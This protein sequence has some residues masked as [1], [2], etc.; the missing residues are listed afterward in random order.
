[1]EY[2]GK[3]KAFHKDGP[4]SLL[5]DGGKKILHPHKCYVGELI[6]DRHYH[7]YVKYAYARAVLNN[8]DDLGYWKNLYRIMQRDKGR[9]A[10]FK[11][12]DSLIESIKNFGFD[13]NFPIPVDINYDILD[14]S[15]RLAVLLAL[16]Q[17][18]VVQIYSKM[19]KRYEKNRFANF[20]EDYLKNIDLVR[21]E[22]FEKYKPSISNEVF[23]T[24][25]GMGLPVWDD[26]IDF[27]GKDSIKRA[28]LRKFSDEEYAAF[29]KVMYSTDSIRFQ[30]LLRK[31]WGIT[32]FESAAGIIIV[33]KPY[34]EMRSIKDSIRDKF[35]SKVNE[36]H[37][38]SILHTLDDP[39]DVKFFMDKLDLYKP[40][41]KMTS[42]FNIKDNL[43]YMILNGKKS[44]E[45]YKSV[46]KGSEKTLL[47]LI[48]ERFDLVI[49]DLD[50]TIVNSE[51][52][53]VSGYVRTLSEYG[54]NISL[55]NALKLFAGRSKNDNEKFIK[56]KWG[57]EFSEK[58]KLNK[59]L[60]IH[61]QKKYMSEVDGIKELVSK[62]KCA[63]AVASGSS[64]ETI[65]GSLKKIGLELEFPVKN[66]FSTSQV[67]KGKPSPDVFIL[68]SKTLGVDPD[69]CIVIEDSPDGI[70]AAVDA[71]M[72]FI[73]FGH[74][75]HVR[76]AYGN[77]DLKFMTRSCSKRRQIGSVKSALRNDIFI[78]SK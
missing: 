55:K 59:K 41:G 42:V 74:G 2:I 35:I 37:Y 45:E 66:R 31:S 14:G 27:F 3:H 34:E 56:K 57:V 75:E 7:V 63:K 77:E 26:I 47:D 46:I 65:D 52:I 19:S 39:E 6:S 50:G 53:N 18:P 16:N 40:V 10:D 51:A 29:I 32:R 4:G 28:F 54:I 13:K 8:R 44:Y 78:N 68:V 30:T 9:N 25:W 48:N 22:L 33:D 60:W 20:S 23:I 12:F 71:G 43:D 69:R 67:E 38:D 72:H 17:M 36:Y 76:H 1:M 64:L 61:E 15:H 70:I 21:K 58:Q 24:V 73:W 49:F 11:K 5:I 62:V